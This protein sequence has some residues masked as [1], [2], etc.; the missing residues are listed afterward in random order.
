MTKTN[1]PIKGDSEWRKH[2]NK[3]QKR[4]YWKRER[5]AHREALKQPI[6]DSKEEKS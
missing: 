1:R 2:R 3:P 5:Q 6:D 4:R